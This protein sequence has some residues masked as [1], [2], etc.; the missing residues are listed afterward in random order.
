DL[1][2]LGR[3]GWSNTIFS[4]ET[5]SKP[6]QKGVIGVVAVVQGPLH[7]RQPAGFIDSVDQNGVNVMSAEYE[8]LKDSYSLLAMNALGEGQMNVW[9]E[10]GDITVGDLIVA[11]STPGKG[12]RQSDDVVHSYTVAKARESIMFSGAADIRQI[13]CIYLCG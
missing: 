13:A 3:R 1:E 2:C 7:D 12:M 8:E 5:S 11:S 10:G 9:G 4:V 6:N